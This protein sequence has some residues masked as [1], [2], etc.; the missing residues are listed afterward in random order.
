[1]TDTPSSHAAAVASEHEPIAAIAARQCVA[2]RPLDDVLGAAVA[3]A[4]DARDGHRSFPDGVVARP[5]ALAAAARPRRRPGRV[6]AARAERRSIRSRGFACPPLPT[7]L[8][9]STAAAVCAI[10]RRPPSPTSLPS[11]RRIRIRSRCGTRTSNA[12]AAARAFKAGWPSPRIAARDPYAVRGLVL[13]AVVATFVAAGGEH[14]KRIAAAFDW[15][16]EV[17]PANFRVDAWV[18]PPS[19]TGKPP[20]ILAGIH[21][22]ETGTADGETNR[23]GLCSGRQYAHRSRDRQARSRRFQQRRRTPAT[24]RT[25][26]R[27][28]SAQEYR[29]K[30]TGTGTATLRGAGDDLTWAFNAIPD[31]P[32]TIAL[33]K[34]PGATKLRLAAVVL[35]ARRRLWRDRSA[36]DVSRAKMAERAAAARV[37]CTGRR[38]L[39]WC[40]RRRAPRNGVG[41]TIKDLTDHPWAG[42]EVVMTLVARDEGGNEGKSEPFTFRLPE[43]VFTKPLARALVEQRRNLALD[44]G[45][46]PQ[47]TTRSMRLPWR[48]KSSRP[49]P[50]FISG[51]A[52]SSGRWFA[53][54][55]TTT[56][57]T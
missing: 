30:I 34:D 21:P 5:V 1:M 54:K 6:R 24:K 18:T 36:G 17:L 7:R 56:C 55:P 19:Y 45:A 20:I 47:V 42:A 15:Q 14:W 37:R 27:R 4:G 29:F 13:V 11:P 16:G 28:P 52:R 23:T 43:R 2:A 32:P 9:G 22:G 33:A 12:L 25:S 39:R 44:A 49:T 38:I 53:P 10:A 50:E 31:K 8:A 35:P 51:C 3:G 46:R 26:V 40:C 48:R 41:Q 57:A